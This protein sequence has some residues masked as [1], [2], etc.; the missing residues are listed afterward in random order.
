MTFPNQLTLLRIFLTPIFIATLF[1]ESLT[2]RY[3]SFFLFLIA[4]LTD[5]YD[6]Y[7]ARKFNSVSQ[8]GK[9]LDPLADK[10]LVLSTFFALFMIG[11]VQLWMV[12][13]IAARDLAITALR[14]YAMN[15][16]RPLITSTFAKWKT[17]SQMTAIYVILIYLII[18]QKMV[19]AP[20]QYTWVQ[21]LEALELIDK[22]MYMVTLIT[23]TTG[24]HYLIENRHHVKGFAIA[25][26]RLFLPT[27]FF[28]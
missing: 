22:L 13:V 10:I 5:W 3:I 9:F 27:T 7:I 16:Q 19:D 18:K 26:C 20:E 28:S 6:G 2:Y 12:L 11:Q 17:A 4:S 21:R 25:F 24:V 15:K 1:V 23:A 8:W 14:I